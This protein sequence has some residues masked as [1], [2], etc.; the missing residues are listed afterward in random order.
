V[1]NRNKDK[2]FKSNSKKKHAFDK[3]TKKIKSK[4]EHA[5]EA[6]SRSLTIRTV[7]HREKLE[8]KETRNAIF[9]CF[10]FSPLFLI[11]IK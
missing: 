5:F 7:K 3:K 11:F 1:R 9:L 10:N 4:E 8:R 6:W 2:K